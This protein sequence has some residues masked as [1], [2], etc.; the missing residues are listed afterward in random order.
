[1]I[2]KTGGERNEESDTEQ[3]PVKIN[4]EKIRDVEEKERAENKNTEV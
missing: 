3:R 4:R 1:M 2:E